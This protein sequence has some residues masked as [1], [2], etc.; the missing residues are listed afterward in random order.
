M[1]RY[2][3]NLSE[4]CEQLTGLNFNNLTGNAFDRIDNIAGSAIPLIFS[5]RYTLLDDGDDRTDLLR[6]ILEHYWE[7]EVC[8]YTPSD[9]VL[10]INRKLN[11]IAPYYNKRYESTKLDFPIFE[12]TKYTTDGTD[13]DTDTTGKDTT[14]KTTNS[15]TDTD[16]T[17]HTGTVGNES[18]ENGTTKIA[19][20]HKDTT[21]AESTLSEETDTDDVRA[22]L[23][24]KDIN[25]QY[26][27]TTPQGSISGITDNDYL[28]SYGKTTAEKETKAVIHQ[29]GE[30]TDMNGNSYNHAE[31]YN[32]CNGGYIN[33]NQAHHA[34]KSDGTTN[35]NGD[36]TDT[37]THGKGIDST[38]TYGDTITKTLNHGHIID[39]IGNEN[40]N[41]QHDGKDH[42]ITE[43]KV[44]SSRSYSEM[45]TLYRE[46]MINIYREIIEEL[47]ELFFIIY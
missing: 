34:S 10:R 33:S 37:T 47:H 25:W 26:D 21:T 17:G 43:G 16:I 18:K 19:N 3:L 6:M 20:L 44:N 1:A 30:R 22:D 31:T 35:T 27:N 23:V 4:I 7:Y 45:L 5:D 9:F 15:G 38:T 12:D 36:Y 14:G 2:T 24:A 32:D 39:T 40:T 28:T 8:T 42:R 46:T 13:S 41:F 29:P 11:E